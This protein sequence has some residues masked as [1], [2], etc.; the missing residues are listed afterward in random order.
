MP[1]VTADYVR[2]PV[3]T[4]KPGDTIR[5]ITISRDRGIKALY[6]VNRKV[7]VTY[8]FSRKKGWTRDSAQAW[9]R[10]NKSN[11]FEIISF[12]KD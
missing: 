10:E 8:L 5:T 9:L 7:I 11:K 1:E 6:A 4:K 2:L 3:A 12:S